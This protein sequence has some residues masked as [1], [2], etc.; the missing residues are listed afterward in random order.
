MDNSITLAA[1]GA[2]R[3][4]YQFECA[5]P[6]GFFEPPPGPTRSAKQHRKPIALAQERQGILSVGE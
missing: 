3:F 6:P 5:A 1:R 4:A 2:S